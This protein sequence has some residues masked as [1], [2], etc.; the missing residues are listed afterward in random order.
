MDD[1]YAPWITPAVLRADDVPERVRGAAQQQLEDAIAIGTSVLF[2]AT[3]KQWPGV[4]T[5][6]VYPCARMI[7]GLPR[8]PSRSSNQSDAV[9]WSWN[10]SWGTWLDGSLTGGRN[11]G[12]AFDEIQLGAYPLV[13][14]DE[15]LFDGVVFPALNPDTAAPNYRISERLWL[16]RL[17]RQWWPVDGELEFSVAFHKGDA[18][19]ASGEVAIKRYAIEIVKSFLGDECDLPTR[20]SSITRQGL[21]ISMQ[22]IQELLQAG[23]TGVPIV[24]QWVNST[25]GGTQR[26]HRPM[27]VASP[28][29]P[30]QIRR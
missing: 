10:Y 18:P 15:I 19:P 21:S 6:L 27:A 23:L 7:S 28:R 8:W 16:Q 2:T 1:P 12:L 14:I 9:G 30:R 5:D 11:Q 4:T 17:D 29:I 25:N 3:G 24:D 20:V 26:A 13:S 22:S